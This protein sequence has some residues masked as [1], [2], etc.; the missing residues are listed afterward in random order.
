M[1]RIHPILFMHHHATKSLLI[2]PIVERNSSVA[3]QTEDFVHQST[4]YCVS[5]PE[6]EKQAEQEI[7]SHTSTSCNNFVLYP[8][9]PLQNHQ[10]ALG[11]FKPGSDGHCWDNEKHLQSQYRLFQDQRKFSNMFNTVA[12]P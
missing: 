2:L 12:L 3:R 7:A 5:F 11:N 9:N 6:L 8:K 4:G 10:Q 1:E